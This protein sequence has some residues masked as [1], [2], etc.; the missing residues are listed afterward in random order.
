MRPPQSLSLN[1]KNLKG[2]KIGSTILILKYKLQRN[3]ILKREDR[4]VMREHIKSAHGKDHLAEFQDNVLRKRRKLLE[5][6]V[7]FSK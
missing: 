3:K 5:T 2:A 7:I 1:R 6:N 4:E